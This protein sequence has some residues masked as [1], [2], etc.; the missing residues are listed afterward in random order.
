ME[1]AE[2]LTLY[3][4]QAPLPCLFSLCVCVEVG[5]VIRPPY[6]DLSEEPGRFG[7]GRE[8]PETSY[9]K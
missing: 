8:R 2:Y 5:K 3:W 4:G 9:A 7:W 6:L 1:M